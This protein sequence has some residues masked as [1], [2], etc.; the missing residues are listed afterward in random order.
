MNKVSLCT[1]F[2][3]ILIL[4]IVKG[5][6]VK[7]D[8][9]DEW[10]HNNEPV[11]FNSDGGWCWFQD[12]R[13]LIDNGLLVFGSVSSTGDI[14][15]THYDLDSGH[16]DTLTIHHEFQ[17]NDHAQP[18]LMKRSDGRY[19]IAYSKHFGDY[20]YW[21]ISTEPND[22]TQ[23]DSVNT[24][25][26]GDRVTYS[27]LYHLTENGQTYN[28]HRGIDWHPNVMVSDN[29]GDSWEYLGR[30]FVEDGE[31]PYPRY[32]TN[33][34]NRVHFVTTNAHPRDYINNI[35][36]GYIENDRIYTSDGID[37]GMIDGSETDRTTNDLTLI[38]EGDSTNVPWTS[39]IQVDEEGH[40]Y[41]GYSVTKDRITTGEGGM[42]HRYRYAR[43]DGS[44]WFDYEIAYAGSRLYPGEDEYTGL[45]ALHPDNPDMVYI[46]TD[47][48]PDT[49]EP[50]ISDANSVRHYEIFQGRTR[51]RGA[52]WSW[53]AVTENSETDNIRP[54]IVSD[55]NDWA[56]LW[57]RGEYR[58]YTDYNLEVVGSIS[59][60]N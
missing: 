36:H 23:W 53:R 12:E 34:K 41:I 19:L 31:R 7:A 54:V 59:R 48:H 4:F 52:T 60:Q 55:G 25:N 24:I 5:C 56:V 26:V 33:G 40:P 39:D 10:I 44:Q 29:E 14:T 22:P 11:V 27:N 8:I 45:I 50:L 37:L 2:C 57:L 35:Y 38:F 51:D 3:L 21:R 28:F 58:T 49:G 9:Y 6:S 1:V 13:A 18:A 17:Q 30:L 42:D 47:V 16:G 43:W 46:S 32:A 20:S 15:L